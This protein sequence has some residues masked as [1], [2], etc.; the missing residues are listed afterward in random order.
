MHAQQ[1]L[2]NSNADL[3]IISAA[4]AQHATMKNIHF[5]IV[6]HSLYP[7]IE[8]AMVIIQQDKR[9]TRQQKL[10]NE[11]SHFIK[12]EKAKSIISVSGYLIN[13]I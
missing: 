7:A 12:Q 11:F 6:D 4:Q 13:R 2:L 3:A 5:C 10:I 9:T 8:Q 1:L